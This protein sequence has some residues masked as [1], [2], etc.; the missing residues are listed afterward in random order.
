V[1]VGV[2]RIGT[3]LPS[4]RMVGVRIWEVKQDSRVLVLRGDQ[5]RRSR[6]QSTIN[7]ATSEFV[8][9]ELPICEGHQYRYSYCMEL[10]QQ[11]KTS[12]LELRLA[13]VT[14]VMPAFNEQDIIERTVRDWHDQV[15]AKLPGADLLVVDDCS[16]DGTGAVLEKLAAQLP[17]V[18]Y[19]RPARNGG[20]GKALRFGFR[21][22]QA[23]YI[24]QTDS[25]QQ[26]LPSEFWKLWMLRE[27]DFVFGVRKDRAD[28][29][30]RVVIT[31]TMRILNFVMWGIWIRDAN[32][33]FKLMR[34]D[35][36]ERVLLKIS[37]DCFIPMVEVSILSRKMRYSVAEVPC[38]HL[39][40]RGGTQS[41]KGA[42]RW[43]RVGFM[44]ARQLLALRLQ[45]RQDSTRQR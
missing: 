29:W 33:P 11:E 15:I 25:D 34:R 6:N 21:Q 27:K 9:L 7:V 18:R 20:H 31:R 8:W 32:C 43:A 17:A 2:N 35:A 36:L 38:T 5:P 13:M 39:A 1:G 22:T 23:E 16:T 4:Q 10:R 45:F 41:L 3:E 42:M 24:F 14:I 37:E 19:A 44:C 40:R 12:L 30:I 28:G 26:H